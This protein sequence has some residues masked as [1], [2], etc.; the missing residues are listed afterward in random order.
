LDELPEFGHTILESLRQPIEDKI[1]T[2]SRAQGTVTYPANFMLL[3]S[4]NPCPCGY[5]GDPVKECTCSPTQVSRYSKRISGPMLDRIDIFVEVPRV[6][7]E[8]LSAPSN[9][10][11]S[12]DVRRRTQAASDTQQRRFMDTAILNNAEMGPN[13]VYQFCEVEDSAQSLIQTA[14]HQMQLSARA[15]H[16][17]LKV[18]RTIADLSGADTIGVAHI[19]EVLQYRPTQLQ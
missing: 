9:A 5:L 13:E 17:I 16:R 2:I 7:F 8:K 18:S 12:V 15:Y 11:T 3:G 1:V 14:M 4:M 6:D 10:E 19:A